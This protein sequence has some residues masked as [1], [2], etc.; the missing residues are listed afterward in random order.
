MNI[1]NKKIE[2]TYYMLSLRIDTAYEAF[3]ADPHYDNFQIYVRAK[4]ALFEFCQLLIKAEIEGDVDI[5]VCES[6]DG[7]MEKYSEIE[8]ENKKADEDFQ[9]IIDELAAKY[10]S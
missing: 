3:V 6:F 7:F 4:G 5:S 1:I 8:S 2:K 10:N 9:K